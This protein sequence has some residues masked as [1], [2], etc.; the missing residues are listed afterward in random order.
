MSVLNSKV[1]LVEDS[2]FLRRANERALSKAGFEV[3]TAADGEEVLRVANHKLPDIILREV[4]VTAVRIIVVVAFC[5]AVSGM[6]AA[7]DAERLYPEKC[8][9][10]HAADG[11]GHTAAATKMKVPDLRSK[12]VQHMSDQ[13]LYATT[14]QGNGH[15]SYPHAFLH[16]GLTEQQI[17]D[18]IKYIRTFGNNQE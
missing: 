15:K 16:R 4:L 12:R 18:L 7:Q 10:C 11:R 9:S 3:S 8:A 1:L 13:D 6:S 14:A 5:A 2:K 17:R